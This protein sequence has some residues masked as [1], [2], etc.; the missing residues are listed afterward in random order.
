MGLQQDGFVPR[1]PAPIRG[2]PPKAGMINHLARTEDI[3]RLKR[4]GRVGYIDLV[5]DPEPVTGAGPYA[6]YVVGKPAVLAASQRVRLVQ[7][8]ID[9]FCRRRP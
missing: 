5:V 9:T 3:F 2:A 8:Q 4:R 1:P 6:R 7:Q